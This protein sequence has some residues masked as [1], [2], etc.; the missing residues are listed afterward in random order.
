MLPLDRQRKIACIQSRSFCLPI[1]L[2]CSDDPHNFL[3]RSFRKVFATHRWLTNHRLIHATPHH[4]PSPPPRS[5]PCHCYYSRCRRRQRQKRGN[6]CIRQAATQIILRP[7]LLVSWMQQQHCF[8]L[9]GE[10]ERVSFGL[11]FHG[12]S[13][14]TRQRK[15]HMYRVYSVRSRF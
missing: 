11:E 7:T 6:S 3:D 15:S 9:L 4:A 8:P 5:Q 12:L 2:L 13:S 14:I 1:I 10:S